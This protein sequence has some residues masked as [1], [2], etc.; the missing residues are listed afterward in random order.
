MRL[1]EKSSLYR[2]FSSTRVHLHMTCYPTEGLDEYVDAAYG[3]DKKALKA[4][5]RNT[6]KHSIIDSWLRAGRHL[7]CIR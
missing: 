7:R 2:Q 3:L 4:V 5:Q 6:S 1:D